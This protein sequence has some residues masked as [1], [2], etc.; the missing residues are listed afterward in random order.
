MTGRFIERANLADL[1]KIDGAGYVEHDAERNDSV[2][3]SYDTDI[4]LL[5]GRVVNLLSYATL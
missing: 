1:N 5:T 2:I 3:C 4:T